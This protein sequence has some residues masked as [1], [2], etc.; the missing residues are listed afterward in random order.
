MSTFAL[1]RDFS[2]FGRDVPSLLYS[3]PALGGDGSVSLNP[4]KGLVKWQWIA[5]TLNGATP[6]AVPANGTV[7]A[8]LSVASQSG[9]GDFEACAL[10]WN[11]AN[12]RRCAVRPYVN[13]AVVSR[14]L[15]ND[16]I[17]DRLMFGTSQLPGLLPQSIY[18]LPKTSWKFEIRDLSGSGE[19]VQPVV[20]GRRFVDRQ[21]TRA[22]RADFLNQ[23]HPFWIGPVDPAN[24]AQTGPEVTLAANGQVQLTF[25][26]PSDADFLCKF[27]LDDSTAASGNEPS[28]YAQVVENYTK[29]GLADLP[30]STVAAS[31]NLGLHWRD[32]MACPSVSVT[33]FPG[34]VVRAASLGSPRGGFTHLFP[35]NTQ[36]VIRFTSLDATA[37]T[38]RVAL[39]GWLVYGKEPTDRQFSADYEAE[40]E[41]EAQGAAIKAK[42]TPSTWRR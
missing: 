30:L 21:D 12:N 19:T 6:F 8:N 38:L 1:D 15:A 42:F 10:Y 41:R 17:C 2:L 26:V 28:L 29:R 34:G 20:F 40:L 35:R 36:V 39:F 5:A 11:A 18:C 32:F 23:M 22:R 13:T 16:V 27:L 9:Q 14:Y 3:D 25:Q 31:T 33:G 37:I 24:A 7:T 4:A